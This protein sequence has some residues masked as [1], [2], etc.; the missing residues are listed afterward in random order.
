MAAAVRARAGRESDD[1]ARLYDPAVTTAT[2]VV[3]AAGHGTRM[4]SAVPKMLHPLC[5]RVMGLWPVIAALEA[6]AARVVVVCGP[7]RALEPHLPDG[8]RLAVQE[9]PLGTGDAVKAASGHIDRSGC[10]LVVNGDVPLITGAF[11]GEL[12]D[13]HAASDAAAT[14]VT[15][16]LDD[17]TGYGRVVRASDGSVD[18]VVETKPPGDATPEQLAIRE[19]NAGI[20]AFDGGPLLDALARLRADNAQ[21]EYYLPD[22]LPILGEDGT[23]AG[24]HILD[25]PD[26][27][28]GVNDRVD[29]AEV[30]AVAQRRINEGHMRAGVTIVDPGATVVDVDVRVGPDTV[31]E[32]GCS[33]RGATAIG[34]GCRVGPHCTLVDAHLRDEVTVLHSYLQGCELHDRVTVGPFAYLRP[35]TVMRKGSKAGTFVEIKNSDVGLRTKVPHLSYLGDADV[36]EDA[37]L[38]AG[39]ITANYDGVRKHRTTIGDR[40]KSSVDVSFVAPVEVGDDAWTAAGSVITDDVPPGALGVARERQT[41]VDG[42]AERRRARDQRG[43]PPAA[44]ERAEKTHHGDESAV[45]GQ[46]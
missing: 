42:Y 28:L 41:N 11:L 21:G 45:P 2:V 23:R 15:M 37:N 32:P 39:T 25:D 26:L 29:L 6:G 12:A 1:L 40:V 27:A 34:S 17:P 31:I 36:G 7:D 5:G 18:R 4:R 38:G 16:E 14:L 35:G 19:V 44:P 20:Y 10:V 9:E 3:L 13:A 8:V 33:L 24:A 43:E 46:A 22:V 30:R